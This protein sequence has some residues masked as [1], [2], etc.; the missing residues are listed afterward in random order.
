MNVRHLR[1]CTLCK[2][3]AV[4]RGNPLIRS[5]LQ[6]C[7]VTI[8][9]TPTYTLLLMYSFNSQAYISQPCLQWPI[10][11]SSKRAG[12]QAALLLDRAEWEVP[13]YWL[14]PTS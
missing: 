13:H 8:T 4:K 14:L 2:L 9:H 10:S 11:V 12:L 7:S 1:E 6:P 5:S 3:V